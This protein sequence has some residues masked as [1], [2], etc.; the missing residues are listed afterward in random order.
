MPDGLS[1]W[2]QG[3]GFKGSAILVV[4]TSVA[5]P[6]AVHRTKRPSTDVAAAEGRG[7]ARVVWLGTIAPF[8]AHLLDPAG[9]Q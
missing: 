6:A 4:A 9:L 8:P 7:P 2:T 1:R 5:T 3:R